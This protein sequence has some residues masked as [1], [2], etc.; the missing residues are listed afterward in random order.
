MSTALI[1]RPVIDPA[2][3][4]QVLLKGDLRQLT[5]AQKVNYYNAVCQ[6]IGL[7][8]LTQPFAYIVLNGKE[9]LYAKKDATEQLRKIHGISIDPKAFVREVI[10]GVYVVT[11]AASTPEGRT[12]VSTGAVAIEGLKGEAR[13]NAMLK[14][15]TKAKRRVTLSICGLGMLDE[16]EAETIPQPLPPVVIEAPMN[17]YPDVPEGAYR[18]VRCESR[19]FGGVVALV[20]RDGVE[21]TYQV[22]DGRDYQLVEKFAQ[23]GVLISATRVKSRDGV[24]KLKAIVKYR[25]PEELA[26]AAE[27]AEQDAKVAAQTPTAL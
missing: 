16:T 20:D 10:E 27:I 5:P 13:A 1:E 14:A 21:D 15:E 9:C 8:P 3:V 19:T 23:E 12:D 26:L 18:I 2:V 22:P 17:A 24:K 7:N 25:T 11:A 6:S 4:E